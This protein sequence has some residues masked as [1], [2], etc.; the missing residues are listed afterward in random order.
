MSTGTAQRVCFQL[1][2]DPAR[3]DEYRERHA[4]VWPDMLRAI[5]ASGRRNYSLFLREDGLLIGYYEVDDDDAAQ[6]ALADDPRTA[7][8]EAEMA[9]FFVALDGARPDQGAPRLPEVFH[10]EDQL[11]ALDRDAASVT[12]RRES[13]D[14]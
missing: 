10:L 2:V 14:S 5:E 12:T 1:Q 9:E 8:W 4:A 3:L 6:A 11:A 7:P 13:S